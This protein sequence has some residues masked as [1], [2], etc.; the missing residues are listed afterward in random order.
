MIQYNH[1][2][3]DNSS[4]QRALFYCDL[5][6]VGVLMFSVQDSFVLFV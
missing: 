1:V 2:P 4:V 6:F 5:M 3:G